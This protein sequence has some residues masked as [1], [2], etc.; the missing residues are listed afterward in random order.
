M[1]IEE[2]DRRKRLPRYHGIAHLQG[3]E[4][5][6][7]QGSTEMRIFRPVQNLRYLILEENKKSV[8]YPRTEM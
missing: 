5:G 8:E 2:T 6:E 1:K 3:E 4:E 7:D